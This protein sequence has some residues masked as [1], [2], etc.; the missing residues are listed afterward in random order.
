MSQNIFSV[1]QSNYK[2]LWRLQNS[3]EVK[4]CN[5]ANSRLLSLHAAEGLMGPSEENSAECCLK[6]VQRLISYSHRGL[7][8]A[9]TYHSDLGNR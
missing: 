9:P 5:A 8:F 4:S 2:P 3:C 7:C 1:V 6:R